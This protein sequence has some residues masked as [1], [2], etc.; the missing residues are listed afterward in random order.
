MNCR[1]HLSPIR[2][3][4]AARRRIVGAAQ[5]DDVPRLVL[6]HTFALQE[7]RVAEPHFAAGSETEE[8]LGRV[9]TEVILL[10]V[11][12]PR[13][14]NFSR[15]HRR[16]F[17]V[18]DGVELLDLVLGIILDDDPQRVQHGH[19]PGGALVEILANRILEHHQI[20]EAVVL[21][22]ADRLA[23]IADR[24]RCVPPTAK[25]ADGRHARIIP[26]ADTIFLDQ[27][28][29]LSL[30][31]H[32]VGEVEPGEF[33]LLRVVDVEGIEAPVVQRTVNLEFERADRVRHFLNGIGLPMGIVVHRVEAPLVAGT[34]MF[35]VQNAVE[36]RVAHDEVFGRHV[37]LRP[38]HVRAVGELSRFHPFEKIEILLDRPI[39]IRA[40]LPR[41]SERAAVLADLIGGEAAHIGLTLPDE[42]QRPLVELLEIIGGVVLPVVP[43]EAEPADIFLDRID[44]LD[45]FLGGVGVVEAEVAGAAELQGDAEVEADRLRVADVQVAVWLGGEPSNDAAAVLVGFEILG[46]DAPHEVEGGG[47]V[48]CTHS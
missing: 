10:D 42:L 29:Q 6:D 4:A 7:V 19:Y 16:I 18:V 24:F 47:R 32:G 5:L 33:D 39:A 34:M 23:E 37:D 3:R 28:Q 26:A 14:R 15:S 2:R 48:C 35:G 8:L 38:Q 36:H 41:L 30:A 25:A 9:F 11:E 46:D 44:V 20:G 1:F 22:D 40:V 43:A 13:E 45:I 17:R 12:H 31:H 27:F 21:R